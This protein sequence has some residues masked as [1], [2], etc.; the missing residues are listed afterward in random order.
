M[1]ILRCWAVLAATFVCCLPGQDRPASRPA[2]ST[3][4]VVGTVDV[5]KAYDLYP[6]TQKER[7]RL[8]KLADGSQAQIDKVSRRIEE[9]K[10]S[11]M[12]LNEGTLEREAK[13]LDLEM[14]MAERNGLAKL[15]GDQFEFE[16]LRMRLAIYEDIDAAIT[17]LARDRGVH[18]VLRLKPAERANEAADKTPKAVQG[19]VLEFERREVWFAADELDLTSDLIK[20]LQVWPLQPAR[21]GATPLGDGKA[22]GAAPASGGG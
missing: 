22:G 12:V 17:H 14:A 10:A 18:L 13:Q 8:K 7:E 6:R 5:N 19:R 11:V 4:L 2:G 1:S 15:L 9:L 3:G 21:D 16:Q 20:L